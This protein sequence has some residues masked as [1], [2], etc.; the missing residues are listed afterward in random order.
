MWSFF[1]K[2]YITNKLYSRAAGKKFPVNLLCKKCSKKKIADRKNS[3]FFKRLTTK[4]ML[5]FVYTYFYGF[6]DVSNS[7]S[8]SV[9][10]S[11]QSFYCFLK[12]NPN[13]K[14]SQKPLS[15]NT[16]TFVLTQFYFRSDI[17]VASR[18]PMS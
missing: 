15:N 8:D 17:H 3:K 10:I 16:E 4:K 9:F 2:E 5:Y 1:L 6:E 13:L 11:F 7:W 14:K 12:T 18:A